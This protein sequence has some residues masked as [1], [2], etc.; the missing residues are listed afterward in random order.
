MAALRDQPIVV[1]GRMV[2]DAEEVLNDDAVLKRCKL[3]TICALNMAFLLEK[4]N[5]QVIP[6]GELPGLSE[7]LA[8]CTRG[9]AL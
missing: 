4:T 1:D 3:R 8:G 6:A 7:Q 5:E 9:V 2:H